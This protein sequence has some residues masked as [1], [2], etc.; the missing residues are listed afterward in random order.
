MDGSSNPF[1]PKLGRFLYNHCNLSPPIYVRAS[2]QSPLASKAAIYS[3]VGM[4]VLENLVAH[5]FY[6]LGSILCRPHWDLESVILPPVHCPSNPLFIYFLI[7]Y[8][9][10]SSLTLLPCLYCQQLGPPVPLSCSLVLCQ[11]SVLVKSNAPHLH[12]CS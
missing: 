11:S 10:D 6:S 3:M 2:R 1:L 7:L 12:C 4:G 9:Y 8:C 5:F